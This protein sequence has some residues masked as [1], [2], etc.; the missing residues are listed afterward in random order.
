MNHVK[1]EHASGVELVRSQRAMEPVTD[2]SIR[3][4]IYAMCAA[5]VINFTGGVFG[6]KEVSN[7]NDSFTL[8]EQRQTAIEAAFKEQ[9]TRTD[10]TLPIL[11]TGMESLKDQLRETR[12]T[13]K[14]LSRSMQTLQVQSEINAKTLERLE[15]ALKKPE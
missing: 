10:T 14:E 15:A 9:K 7:V 2:R 8:F 5:T 3:R 13:V 4:L 1:P 11:T 6:V 12:E